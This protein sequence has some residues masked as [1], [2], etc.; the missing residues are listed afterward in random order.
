MDS[1]IYEYNIGE[2]QIKKVPIL[3]LISNKIKI[4]N[5]MEQILRIFK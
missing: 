3:F 5:I 4:V 1:H 2:H